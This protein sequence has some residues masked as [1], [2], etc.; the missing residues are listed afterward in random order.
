MNNRY[1]IKISDP[2]LRPGLTIETEC[3]EAYVADT[4]QVAMEIVREFNHPT[5]PEPEVTQNFKWYGTPADLARAAEQL[6]ARDQDRKDWRKT[7]FR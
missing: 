7:G 5:P 2:L 4:L 6:K 1:K 3:S